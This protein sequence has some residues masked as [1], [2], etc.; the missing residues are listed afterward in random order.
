MS[1]NCFELLR[2]RWAKKK[3]LCVGLD[4]EREK[5]PERFLNDGELGSHFAFN[6]W[7]VDQ[8]HEHVCAFKPNSAFYECEED[9]GVRVLKRTIQ[10]INQVAPDVPVILDVKRGDIGNSS[11]A[12][13]RSAFD[14]NSADAVTVNPWL[15]MEA[16]GP[17]LERREKGIFVLCRTSNPGAGEFQDMIV[18]DDPMYV[19]VARHV[20]G[21]WN[22]LGN[23][24]LV[25]GATAPRELELVRSVVGEDMPL[26]IPGVGAQGGKISDVV[27]VAKNSN[28]EGFI[29][30]SSR[31]II[32]NANPGAKALQ[33]ADE[34]ISFL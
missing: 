28:G 29:I 11:A 16:L 6:K 19:H 26:L 5:I 4:I 14:R 2:K 17:F 3:F 8:T 9:E 18:G 33:V 25:V 30:N 32:G 10:Y 27:P 7:I 23:C 12:Y 13:K 24:G 15:G 31:E 21:P 22:A 20:A 34:I 1:R